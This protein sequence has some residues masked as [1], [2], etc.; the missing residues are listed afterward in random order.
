MFGNDT[1]TDRVQRVLFSVLS[2]DE[3][4]RRSACEVTS[5]ELYANGAPVSGGLYDP[6]MGAVD[7][8]SRCATCRNDN[9]DCPGH[10]G[11]IELAVPLFNAIFVDNVKRMLKVVCTTCSACLL[12]TTDVRRK[13][14]RKR[15]DA[16]HAECA[17]IKACPA[18][19][20]RKADRVTWDKNAAM[21][22]HWKA[23]GDTPE[24]SES[25]I[26][27][28]VER[29]FR[30]VPDAACY[31]IGL[32]PRTCRP[33]SFMFSALPVPPIAVR[34]PGRPGPGQRRDDDLTHKLSD[35]VKHNN[36]LAARVKAGT[37]TESIHQLIQLLQLDVLQYIDNTM[38]GV[39]VARMKATQRPLRSI[40]SRLK[41]K[42][43]RVRGNLM[44]KR[45][46]FSARSVITPDP[47]ISIE[48][49]GVP[50]KVAMTLTMPETVREGNLERL[51]AAVRNGPTEF[52]GARYVRSGGVSV[53]LRRPERRVR[54]ELHVGDVV[55]RHLRDGDVVLFNRQP[56]LHRMSM[57]A[58]KVRVMPGNT[59]RLSVMVTPPYNADFDGDEMNLH[60]PQ[61]VTTEHEIAALAGVASQ[62]LTPREH[63]PI[64]G[65]VQDVALGLYL[66]TQPDVRIDVKTLSN[67]VAHFTTHD[68]VLPALPPGQTD[69][70]G[71]TAFSQ[72]L[73]PTLHTR[74]NGLEI[75]SGTH[76]R[77][78]V[79]KSRFQEQSTGVLH[80]VF[81]DDGQ[82]AAVQLL[83]NSQHLTCDWL[84]RNGFSVGIG[85]LHTSDETRK[86]ARDAV[87]AAHAGVDAILRSTH[88]GTF[89]NGSF[90][91]DAILLESNI[92][93]VLEK[94]RDDIGGLVTEDTAK[95][96]SRL[97]AM[98]NAESKGGPINVVQ[99]AGCLGQQKIE[100]ARAPLS[101]EGRT[102]PHFERYDDGMEARG[103]VASSFLTGLRPQEFFFH[104]MAG[105]E[106]LI[107]TAVK[108]VTGDTPIVV[109]EDGVAKYVLIGD[110]I[111]AHLEQNAG[112]VAHFEKRRMELL[113]IEHDVHIPTTDEHG[114]VTWGRV[115]AMTRHDPG[116]EL[117]EIVTQGGRR[118]IVTESKSLLIWHP[119]LGTFKE[120]LTP[121]IV[122]GDFVPVTAKLE[123]PPTGIAHVE[124]VQL[125][126]STGT[127]VGLQLA[128]PDG[129]HVPDYAFAAPDSFVRSL[130]YGYFSAAGLHVGEELV[131]ASAT[132]SR[133]IEGISM[134]CSRLG[135]FAEVHGTESHTISIRGAWAAKFGEEVG[136]L[137]KRDL[138]SDTLAPEAHNDV[139]LDKIV[140]INL[141]DVAKYPKVYDLTIP[142]TLNFGLANGLQVRDT[143]ETGYIQRRLIK[144]LEDCKVSHD[145]SV[146]NASGGVVQFKYGDDGMDAC[147]IEA[148][149]I[150][151]YLAGGLA[152]MARDFLLT[153]GDAARLEGLMTPAALQAFGET[154]FGRL[155]AH[156][157]D[158]VADKARIASSGLLGDDVVVHHAVAFER[159]LHRA[160]RL[161]DGASDLAPA[162]ALDA[163]ERV[164]ALFGKAWT[165]GGALARANLSPKRLL[166][167]H[168]MTA[169]AL[170]Y[171]E[172]VL[173]HRYHAALA[174]P[175]DMV[176]IVAAQ[177]IAEPSTQMVLNSF[178]FT[179]TGVGKSAKGVGRIKELLGVTKSPKSPSMTISLREPM[180]STAES[181]K[182]VRDA[183]QATR[184]RDLV[185]GSTILYDV[186]DFNS[187]DPEDA[188]ICR[189]YAAFAL[190]QA[191]SSAAPW[192]LRLHLDRAR[193]REHGVV[194]LDVHRALDA[195]FIVSVVAS[196]DAA[197]ELVMR[198]RPPTTAG[199][200]MVT[201]MAAFED[202]VMALI[203]RGV[204]GIDKAALVE[205]TTTRYDATA[206]AFVKHSEWC[207]QTSGS[208]LAH[209][210]TVAG[211]DSRR[212]TTDDVVQVYRRL[213][214]EAAR[215]VLLQ[216]L[217]DTYSG[218]TYA[219]FRHIA[220]LVDFMTQRGDVS[221]ITRH[222]M[223]SS[224][225]GPLAKCSYEETVVKL[226]DAGAYG[227]VDLV[228]GVSA[229]IMLGQIAPCGT[230]DSVILIDQERL[231]GLEGLSVTPQAHV[232][233]PASCGA[234]LDS[235][236]A[237]DPLALAG[238]PRPWLTT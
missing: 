28:D 115:T 217:I 101:L 169:S 223:N 20:A 161:F 6:R 210:M 116:T 149:T 68:G 1:N 104:A 121:E 140:E 79:T 27:A 158:L 93:T 77:G 198:V 117:Y 44:G 81:S 17:R 160:A 188:R 219:D 31:R 157:E 227:E 37:K 150:P 200:D 24:R 189:L 180:S 111:D 154:D 152:E 58:H 50:L 194:M 187:T 83:D 201:E 191:N 134:L 211:V 4:R 2:A 18:C 96:G 163:C 232:G 8:G 87:L 11:H 33:E 176:G 146:R 127:S 120:V 156:F 224:D 49:L 202:C 59:F 197:D 186:S 105:R 69:Y 41:G 55:D 128:G 193:L 206:C 67:L 60:A 231:A 15:V 38:T 136:L 86:S 220:L 208:N 78:S 112:D 155:R 14:S 92:M 12:P 212:T 178:H 168:G 185:L 26:A 10:F 76:T 35:I 89:V 48:D 32:D 52:P 133:L 61:S 173:T 47:N 137:A 56:S 218:K 45:V 171:A 205:T 72:L 110:W 73:P 209:V 88:D 170:T 54:I 159:I 153:D 145:R 124:G 130:L 195:A 166:L 7:Y 174:S 183:L 97:M 233:D 3:I 13:A 131:Q 215:A 226:A 228:D 65:V 30:A 107:D 118:V 196:D 138:A 21:E 139:V 22:L 221:P 181:A 164:A 204:D 126:E 235:L 43:G 23:D 143:A 129:K 234:L 85:D 114:V 108:S 46:D 142:T 190:G 213:G 99:M 144:A 216:E 236:L 113:D 199:T 225:V 172:M 74:V 57:M 237:F 238:P 125:T 165:L 182:V 82:R 141:V 214:V 184:M 95:R 175:S 109:M 98:I 29:I 229:N 40:T 203:V 94:A 230:G 39:A 71:S 75:D 90:H 84:M 151:T 36:V 70:S 179:G 192:L 147:S 53:S 123:A 132:S 25:L 64:I 100:G 103:F 119:D 162:A 102:L 9:K 62:I 63:K 106:G 148:Q 51:T 19:G 135:I 177:S 167:H 16:S 66:V 42:E 222:G 207:V 122:V 91:T 5:V 80:S 34:P